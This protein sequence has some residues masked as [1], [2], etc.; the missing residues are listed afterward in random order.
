[1]DKKVAKERLL[2][3]REVFLKKIERLDKELREMEP[4]VKM[5][6]INDEVFEGASDRTERNFNAVLSGVRFSTLE[7]IKKALARLE[8][9]TY[10]ICQ[11]CGD[12][13]SDA[14][15]EA[16]PFASDCIKCAKSKEV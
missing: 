4:L 6:S 2:R 15:I 5:G 11:N 3:M 7:S 1:M 14:R 13:I 16:L 8:N 10:G 9:G 12:T